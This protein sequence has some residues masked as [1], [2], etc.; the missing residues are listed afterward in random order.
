VPSPSR[1]GRYGFDAPPALFG[2]LMGAVP[3]LIIGAAFAGQWWGNVLLAIGVFNA[4]SAALFVQATRRGKFQVWAQEL[5]ALGLKGNERIVDLGCGRGA[6]LTMVAELLPQG[7]AVGVDLWRSVDQSGN[8]ESVTRA[9]AQAEG[10][11]NR[12]ELVTAD[13]RE[14][15][16]KD[17]EFDVVLSSLAIHNI[18]RD[19]EKA[20]REAERVC[21][22]GG[23]ILIVDISKGSVY[24]RQLCEDGYTATLRPV[25]WRMWFGGPWVAASI[26]NAGKP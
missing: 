13:L 7:T 6:V 15:P 14:L 10:V 3:P 2:I 17:A 22:P 5:Q 25:G 23:R 19:R 24:A 26:I 4:A 9:N 16:F 8:Q 1:R 20:I 18:K 21:M 11:A 12:V